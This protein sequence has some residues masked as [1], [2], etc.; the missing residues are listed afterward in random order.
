MLANDATG[1]SEQGFKM[2]HVFSTIINWVLILVGIELVPLLARLLGK[3]L[4]GIFE[5]KKKPSQ[6]NPTRTSGS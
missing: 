4:L 1:T 3:Q 5:P 2:E 6:D